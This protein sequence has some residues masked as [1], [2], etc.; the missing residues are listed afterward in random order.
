MERFQ[1]VTLAVD[2]T[3]VNCGPF[4]LSVSRGINLITSEF[5]PL[6]TAKRLAEHIKN[7][8][9]VYARAGIIVSTVLMGNK[10]E[11][12]TTLLPTLVTHS[13][14]ARE[15]VNKIERRI[16]TIKERGRGVKSVMPFKAMPKLMLI[17]MISFVVIWLNTF[18]LQSG[19]SQE[20][21]PWEMVLRT[22]LT[23]EKHCKL[24][25]GEYVEANDHPAITNDSMPRT[26][27][28]IS[29]GP[30][31]NSQGTYK[32][33]SLITGKKIKRRKWT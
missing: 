11:K 1:N 26:T 5:T 3:F 21:S 28:A 2:L 13:T 9:W 22:K 33:Y 16:R 15:H 12:L 23:F 19:I 31:G 20:Y 17:E 7:I 32:F 4:L 14:A 6:R 27:P 25:F 10:F 29:M 8:L 30:T 18:P 24:P